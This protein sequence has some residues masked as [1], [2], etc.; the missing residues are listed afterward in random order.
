MIFRIK[1]WDRHEIQTF[2]EGEKIVMP[3]EDTEWRAF[4]F[5]LEVDRI[6]IDYFRQYVLFNGEDP[7]PCVKIYLSDES[8]LFGRY[9]YGE[10]EKYYNEVY[11]KLIPRTLSDIVEELKG[12]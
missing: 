6:R 2:E 7:I 10:F 12:D 1:I 8:V 4:T 9:S 11:S 5:G 3:H